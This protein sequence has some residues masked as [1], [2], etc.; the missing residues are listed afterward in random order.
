MDAYPDSLVVRRNIVYERHGDFCH[1]I[2]P[3]PLLTPFSCQDLNL[4]LDQ[5]DVAIAVFR[6]DSFDPMT[7][8][9]RGLVYKQVRDGQLHNIPTTNVCNGQYGTLVGAVPDFVPEAQY[10]PFVTHVDGNILDGFVEAKLGQPPFVTSWR[11]VD[12]ERLSTGDLLF[13]LRAISS[14]GVLPKPALSLT[15]RAGESVIPSS[16]NDVLE[17]TVDAF[18]R[19]QA[20]P[21][22]DV[23]RESARLII[24]TWLGTSAHGKDFA[25]VIN[26]VPKQY[27][28][29]RSAACIINR[30]H[31]RG[32]SSES[33]SQAAKGNILRPVN[34]EDAETCVQL[35]GLILREI[36]WAAT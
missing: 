7:R 16:I 24:S 27:R 9:R 34:H 3:P 33:E 32:K 28:I 2:Y 17:K 30:L 8:L 10:E 15:N 31:P 14:F 19:Q 11:V 12:I 25:D 35:V 4:P 36:G 22:V 1:A 5:R 26:K 6:E 20:V 29:V 21:T 18:H 13:T 23:C